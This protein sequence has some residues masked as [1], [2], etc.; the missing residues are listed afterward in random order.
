[1]YLSKP[2]NQNDIPLASVEWDKGLTSI[3][4]AI[5]SLIA[6]CGLAKWWL[7]YKAKQRKKN[8][9]AGIA[10][11]HDVY[12]LMEDIRDH[13]VDRVILWTGHNGGGIPK[14]SSPFWVS[15]LHWSVIEGR[16]EEMVNYQR[17]H[18][19]AAYIK[20]LQDMNQNSSVRYKVEEMAD[21]LLKRIYTAEGVRESHIYFISVQDQAMF[22]LSVASYAD[23]V[24][25]ENKIT[26]IDLLVERIKFKMGV[27]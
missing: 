25:N 2:M 24:F 10:A 26:N 23:G 17:V 18:V 11:L 4:S 27:L 6:A 12:S 3:A 1:M 14:P 13:G 22:Y 19:D 9:A 15:A 20:M 8:V 16:E 21:C 5:T 7:L